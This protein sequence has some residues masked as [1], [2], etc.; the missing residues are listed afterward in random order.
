MPKAAKIAV[1]VVGFLVGLGA[2]GWYFFSGPDRPGPAR[3]EVVD[4]FSGEAM[5]LRTGD[6]RIER[7]PGTNADGE[8]T[9]YPLVE[10][11]G[12]WVISPPY[13]DVLMRRFGEDD[14]VVIDL[15]TF[16]SPSA[17]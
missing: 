9:L 15:E 16:E 14:R 8:R 1:I 4:V 17:P 10:E 13:R 12:R 5:T 2:I 11:N 6:S 3:V 7:L